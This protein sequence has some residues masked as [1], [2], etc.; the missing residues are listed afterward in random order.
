MCVQR[1]TFWDAFNEY[2]VIPSDS[3]ESRIRFGD[4]AQ[5]SRDIPS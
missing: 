5:I 2:G 4:F 1:K 3:F